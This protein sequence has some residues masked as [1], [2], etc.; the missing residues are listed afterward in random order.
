MTDTPK[1]NEAANVEVTE[2]EL[3][4]IDHA[5]DGLAARLP[6]VP[7]DPALTALVEFA[8]SVDA[9]AAAMA[10]D[11]VTPVDARA[12]A[13][14][15]DAVTAVDARAVAPAA[16]LRAVTPSMPSWPDRA[17]PADRRERAPSGGS[18]LRRTLKRVPIAVLALT[19]ALLAAVPLSSSPDSPLYPL[20]QRIFESGEPSSPADGVRFNLAGARQAL[21]DA[22]RSQ[23][24][25]RAVRL[26]SA[27]RHL[28]EAR[29]LAALMTDPDARSQ[30]DAELSDLDQRVSG[31]AGNKD[32]Q[33]ADTSTAEPGQGQQ[34]VLPGGDATHAAESPTSGPDNGPNVPGSHDPAEHGVA[35]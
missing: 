7:A 17:R 28:A 21:D 5:L 30:L 20:H 24:S 29:R 33:S 27:R 11:A 26:D 23:G 15:P 9:R 25:T 31:L 16:D 22:S 3:I 6:T 35:R 1:P 10:P 32:P 2:A 13:M 14:A 4:A 12:A 19:L 8:R 34:P 18:R